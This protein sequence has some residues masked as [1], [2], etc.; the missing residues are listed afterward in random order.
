MRPGRTNQSN[1][2]PLSPSSPLRGGRC[3]QLSS[4]GGMWLS[5]SIARATMPWKRCTGS[6]KRKEKR[7]PSYAVFAVPACTASQIAMSS[8]L[9]PS[10]KSNISATTASAP[11]CSSA[12]RCVISVAVSVEAAAPSGATITRKKWSGYTEKKVLGKMHTWYAVSVC[13]APS[14]SNGGSWPGSIADP[15]RVSGLVAKHMYIP[16]PCAR[17][18]SSTPDT[19]HSDGCTAG[20]W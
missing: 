1:L 20:R 13:G 18:C 4:P 12:A 15:P 14:P 5:P 19:V 6:S 2:R 9:T 10:Q 16:R 7:P 17:Q 11:G 3:A 8:R